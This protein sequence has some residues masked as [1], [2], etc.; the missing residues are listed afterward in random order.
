MVIDS[1]LLERGLV[2]EVIYLRRSFI[3]AAVFV[4]R[5][6]FSPSLRRQAAYT[7]DDLLTSANPRTA[8][9]WY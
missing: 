7:R 3:D 8:T 6:L 2:V 9:A 5:H 4:A 1:S